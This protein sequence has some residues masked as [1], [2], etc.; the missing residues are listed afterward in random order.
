MADLIKLY[1]EY[2][3]DASARS[4]ALARFV[5]SGRRVS[6]VRRFFAG[7]WHSSP[8]PRLPRRLAELVRRWRTPKNVATP[9]PV[10]EP[11]K[12]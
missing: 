7:L 12:H 1:S 2:G 8:L 5:G 6:P 3:L 4:T 9:P 10:A 11:P